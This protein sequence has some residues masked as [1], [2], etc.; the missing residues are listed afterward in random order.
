MA[1][2][3]NEN[4]QEQTV[5]RLLRRIDTAEYFNG[6]GWTEN[7]AEAQIFCDALEAASTC[8]RLKL[9]NVE[10][11]LRVESGA[12]DVFCTSMC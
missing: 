5:K 12:C 4:L 7:P 11:A 6:D 3:W 8:A 10:L 9:T 1:N 2:V